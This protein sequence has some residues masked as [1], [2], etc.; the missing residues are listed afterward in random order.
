MSETLKLTTKLMVIMSVLS[1]VV[2]CAGPL[3]YKSG[4]LPLQPAMLSLIVSLGIAVIT[5]IA[6]V[7]FY[8]LVKEKGFGHN[9]KFLLLALLIC[10]VPSL[11]VGTQLHKATKVPEIHDITTDPFDPPVFDVVVQLRQDAPNS[12]VYEY[13]GSAEKL[14]NLQHVAYPDL[15]PLASTLSVPQAVERSI[16]I[17][18]S[19]GLDIVNVDVEK[20]MIEATATSFWYGFKDD[21]VVRIQANEQ[22]SRIDLRS[23]S[24]VGRSDIG[25][26]AA[27]ISD[28][29]QYFK[30]EH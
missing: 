14:A 26:N 12:L 9:K 8:C 25:A 21:L 20:G 23:V 24:R 6:T 27:R 28:F 19:Q 15:K 7:L 10:L 2:L 22:G 5:F 1:L 13:Q 16:N 11:L 18:R 3:G 4:A 29:I 17:L 30:A